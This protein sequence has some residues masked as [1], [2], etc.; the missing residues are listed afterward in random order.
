MLH[1]VCKTPL[2]LD[3]TVLNIHTLAT[4]YNRHLL[5]L[6]ERKL[7]DMMIN[8]RVRKECF[9]FFPYLLQAGKHLEK[10]WL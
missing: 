6:L 4:D 8:G 5:D 9:A 7:E 3:N 2:A 10:S 1:S